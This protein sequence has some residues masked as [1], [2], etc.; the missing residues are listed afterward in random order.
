MT[1]A[2]K[3]AYVTG[4]ASG[5]GKAVVQ[6]LVSKGIKTVVADIN[7]SAADAYV[8]S[9]NKAHN[10]SSTSSESQQECIALAVQVDVAD[11]DSQ[12]EAFTSVQPFVGGRIDY[13]FAVA[14]ISE[15]PWIPRFGTDRKD[16]DT[17]FVKPD[18]TTL[19]VDLNGPLYTAALAVQQM[20]RQKPLEDGFRGSIALAA[21]V[22]GFYCVPT[23][24][25]YTAAKHG[26]V[27]FVRSYG[28]FLAEFGIGLNAVCPMIVQTAISSEGFYQQAGAKGLLTPM[29][30]VV[31]SFEEC[32][33][34]CAGGGEC[35]EVGPLTKPFKKRAAAEVLD[36]SAQESI[37]IIHK[38][39][40]PLHIQAQ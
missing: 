26:V 14:G 21:S 27:G 36:G 29:E 30:N 1:K 24:P 28:K 4:G 33:H 13:V 11:W 39:A 8:E 20:R 7:L 15:R 3:T 25:I 19:E 18:L 10:A 2:Q 31:A 16:L 12:L 32:M 37:D 38:R 35:I 34:G 5:I 40:M 17:S 23:L 22:C 9:L 6:M